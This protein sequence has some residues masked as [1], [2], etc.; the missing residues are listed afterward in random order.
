MLRRPWQIKVKIN[1]LGE[2]LNV[3]QGKLEEMMNR[4]KNKALER[5]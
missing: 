5:I 1:T 4:N 3:L 2:R